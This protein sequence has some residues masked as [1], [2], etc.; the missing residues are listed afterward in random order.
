L[1]VYNM[2]YIYIASYVNII[3]YLCNMSY[4]C[5]VVVYYSTIVSS[6]IPKANT[7]GTKNTLCSM[8]YYDLFTYYFILSIFVCRAV[9]CGKWPISDV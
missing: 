2:V 8:I 4:S 6:L 3:I 7:V 9:N 1:Y 5:S